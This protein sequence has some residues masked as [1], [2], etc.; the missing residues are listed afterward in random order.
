M[1]PQKLTLSNFL[2]YGEGLPTLDLEGIRIACLCGQ[3]GHGKSALLD[4][5]TWALWGKGRG[6][7]NDELVHYGRQDML[8]EL[9]FQARGTTYRVARRHSRSG[10]GRRQGGGDL[11][12]HVS[13]GN[14]F[15]AITGNSSRD[16]QSAIDRI[17]GMDYDTFINS[18]FLLQGRADEFT[19]KGPGERKDVLARI[20]GLELY[21]RLEELAKERSRAAQGAASQLESDLDRMRTDVAQKEMYVNDLE[22]VKLE[23]A[24][25]GRELNASTGQLAI[26]ASRTEDLRRRAAALEELRG[27]IQADEAQLNVLAL[28]ISSRRRVVDDYIAIIERRPEI[29]DGFIRL[30]QDRAQIESLD[31]LRERSHELTSRRAELSSALEATRARLGERIRAL[32]K[33]VEDQLRPS[34]KAAPSLEAGLEQARR[35]LDV[36]DSEESEVRILQQQLGDAATRLGQLEEM[37]RQLTNEGQELRSKLELVRDSPQDARCPLCDTE[38]GSDGC[39]RLTEAYNVQIGDKRR[40]YRDNETA[41]KEAQE[42]KAALVVELPKRESR[43]RQGRGEAQ[44]EVALLG[45]RLDESHLAASELEGASRELSI[46]SSQLAEDSFATEERKNLALLDAEIT[47][48]GYD[49]EAHR[50]LSDH[51]QELRPFEQRHWEL[52]RALEVLPAEQQSLATAEGMHR[53]LGADLS[54]RRGEVQVAEA[55]TAELPQWQARHRTAEADHA[56]LQARHEE[57]TRRQG[58]LQARLEVVKQQERETRAKEATLSARLEERGVYDELVRAFSNRGVQAMLIDTILPRIEDEANA[59]LGKMTDNRMHVKLETQRERRGGK[60]EPIETLDIRVSDELGPRAYEMFS[61]GEAFRINLA[62]RIAL[63]KV[64]AHR[65]G[66]RLPTLFI[67]EGFGTQDASGRERIL[68]VISA[69]QDDFEKILVITHLDEMKEAFETR[70]EVQKTEAGSTFSVV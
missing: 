4:A 24:S 33:R 35:R 30:Q 8:V 21:D 34:A 49:P 57:L 37:A 68:D 14:G 43:I 32:E 40:A 9:E 3:N 45:R 10:A 67:D 27:R 54:N 55:A 31:R 17:T 15:V 62:L 23:A 47:G 18:A 50:A 11:Q 1:I 66:A 41:L 56:T 64:L 59:L 12:L 6:K 69:I 46:E 42:G 60:G 5:I 26:I 19:T 48:L 29:E 2:C 65:R 13:S 38:L 25:A 39:L 7:R 63:S 70:I 36:L 44:S 16:T 22:T 58:E 51:L 53:T 20:M 28:D 52:Q 61:G